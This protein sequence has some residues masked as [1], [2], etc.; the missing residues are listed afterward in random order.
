MTFDAYGAY[1]DLLY[2]DKN[3]RA[4]ADYV[5]G[6]LSESHPDVKD[7]LELGCGSG[8]HAK[9]L[10]H[11]GLRVLGI[12]SSEQMLRRAADRKAELDPNQAALVS[13]EFGDMRRYR[14]DKTF[15]AVISLFHVISYLVDDDG[16]GAALDTAAAHLIPGGVFVFDFW[17]GPAVLSEPPVVRVKRIEDEHSKIVRLTEPSLRPECNA[18][19]VNF[20]VWITDKSTG[21][22]S[23][24]TE[25]HSMRYFFVPELCSALSKSGFEC[26]DVLEWMGSYPLKDSSWYGVVRARKK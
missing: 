1:Y 7:I 25:S 2:L 13:F 23:Q 20:T 16:L 4:E 26:I 14:S 18:V 3:Y 19:D 6:L 15:D 12:D 21:L 17:H 8:G 10:V 24:I 11:R 9:H 22:I 5:L